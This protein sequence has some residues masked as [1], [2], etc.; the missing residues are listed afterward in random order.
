MNQILYTGKKKGPIE[1]HKVVLFFTIIT[2]IFGLA[3]IGQGS[4]AIYQDTITK[5]KKNPGQNQTE[6]QKPEVS[7]DKQDNQVIIKASYAKGIQK[8]VYSWNNANE[9]TI[10]MQGKTQIEQTIELP[11]GNNKLNIKIVDM[12]GIEYP[13]EKEY[14]TE[15]GKPTI[16]FSVIENKIKIV[17]TGKESLTSVTYKW[18]NE[19]ETVIELNPDNPTTV[20][21]TIDIKKGLNNLTVIAIDAQ[22]QRQEK[23]QEIKGVTKPNLQLLQDGG[24]LIIRATD[25]EGIEK[26]EYVLNGQGYR[27]RGNGAKLVEYRQ[28]LAE[29]SNEISAQAFNMAGAETAK[30]GKCEY[31]P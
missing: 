22:N 13:F 23:S 4:Y 3:C 7:I 19:A 1:I 25:E 10:Q 20:E 28:K 2:I 15:D 12:D 5:E 6:E 16:T 18:N 9:Q 14:I 30:S 17:V 29:G 21:T 11:V 31:H 27:I 8:I 24:E 26:L